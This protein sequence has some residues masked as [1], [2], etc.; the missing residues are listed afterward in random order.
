MYQSKTDSFVGFHSARLNYILSNS[1]FTV[2]RKGSLQEICLS[3]RGQKGYS[4]H[5]VAYEHLLSVIQ[6]NTNLHIAVEGILQ[7]ELKSL[8]S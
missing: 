1:V 4:S 8:R 6:L 3:D 5:F 2:S 7:I